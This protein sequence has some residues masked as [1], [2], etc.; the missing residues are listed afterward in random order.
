ME[1][2]LLDGD[3]L[4]LLRLDLE[5]DQPVDDARRQGIEAVGGG[6]P[7][8]VVGPDRQIDELVEEAGGVLALEERVQDLYRGFIRVDRRGLLDLIDDDERTG[9]A[10]LNEH[11]RHL[12]GS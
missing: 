3:H 1:N 8:D 12:A 5:D 10:A 2:A 7:E 4:G 9:M 6:E 11:L